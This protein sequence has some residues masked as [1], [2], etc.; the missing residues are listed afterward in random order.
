MVLHLNKHK[1]LS[2][3]DALCHDWLA[4]WFWRRGFLNFVSVFSLFRNDLPLEN[5][6]A[7]NLTKLKIP[8][9]QRC[10]GPS[11]VEIG[12]V[13]VENE[14]FKILSMYFHYFIFNYLPLEKGRALHL[15]KFESPSSKDALGQV[16]LKLAQWFWRRR[17]FLFSTMYFRYFVIISP[18]KRA[19][20][21]I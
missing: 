6:R 12:P 4:Q 8:L 17:F 20:P 14:D 18:W 10:F 13:V 16:W 11:L 3:K 7:L 19:G 5:D 21:F 15:N 2:P 1:F 9:T